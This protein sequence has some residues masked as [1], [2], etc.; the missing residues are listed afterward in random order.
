MFSRCNC[1]YKDLL[2]AL[3]VQRMLVP[4]DSPETAAAVSTGATSVYNAQVYNVILFEATYG[5]GV[6]VLAAAVTDLP[7]ALLAE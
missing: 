1:N 2:P 4:R 5:V 3:L 6:G 7:P